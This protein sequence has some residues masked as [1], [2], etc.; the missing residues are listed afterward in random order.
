MQNQ[1]NKR[2][3]DFELDQNDV[4][5][6][7][8][9]AS[10]DFTPEKYTEILSSLTSLSDSISEITHNSNQMDSSIVNELNNCRNKIPTIV[11]FGSQSSGKSALLN[12]LF[13][14]LNLKSCNGIG[15]KCPI[16]IHAGP[17]YKNEIIVKN[18][19]DQSEQQVTNLSEAEKLVDNIT[20]QNSIQKNGKIIYRAYNLTDIVIIDLP[21]CA[22]FEGY[23][24]YFDHIKNEYLMKPETVILHVVIG[25]QDPDTDMST[26]FLPTNNKIIKVLTHTDFWKEDEKKMEYLH[27]FDKK[28]NCP[29]AIVNNKENESEIINK[30]EIGELKNELIKGSSNLMAI[31]TREHQ[32]KIH[33]FIPEFKNC[34]FKANNLIEHKL[35][36]I[37]WKVPDMRQVVG[38][39]RVFMSK[40]IEKEFDDGSKLANKLS[41]IKDEFTVEQM[42]K[43]H[44]YI[45]DCDKLAIELQKG[46][47]NQIAG[48]EGWHNLVQKQIEILIQKARDEIIINYVKQYCEILK[49]QA[50]VILNHGYKPCTNLAIDN[51]IINLEKKHFKL[52]DN[53]VKK[54]TTQ[55]DTIATQ[56]YNSDDNYVRDYLINNHIQPITMVLEH[57]KKQSI[58]TRNLTQSFENT[59][60]DI[61]K[62]LEDIMDN[63]G[64]FNTFYLAKAHTAQTQLLNFWK[65][66]SVYIHDSVMEKLNK[67]RIQFKRLIEEQIHRV[68]DKDLIE[69]SHIDEHRKSLENIHKK[70]KEIDQLL[71]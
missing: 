4:K 24:S 38:E 29:F 14:G 65:S 1:N 64:M 10:N 42:R 5:L 58:Q 7:K 20:H 8:Q 39:F 25:T 63:N 70:I 19:Q 34:I 9:K 48:T 3:S 51:I 43:F 46:T 59:L 27:F 16:E 36:L 23:N 52:V 68:C 54:V 45:P 60:N 69:P 31:I 50:I 28:F 66:K 2:S 30:F 26:M 49:N 41:A 47:L 12:K 6:K 67:F 55:L 61:P 44:Q 35:E 62:V 17:S 13:P 11:T 22:N 71:I 40:L 15:T 21:G 33:K 32:E 53:I 18:I 56:P 37:G 57:I